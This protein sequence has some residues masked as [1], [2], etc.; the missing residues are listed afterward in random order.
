[1]TQ[2]SPHYEHFQMSDT[3][4]MEIIKRPSTALIADFLKRHKVAFRTKIITYPFIK[5]SPDIL[6]CPTQALITD[7]LKCP[8]IAL[9]IHHFCFLKD[10]KTRIITTILKSPTK[11]LTT[12]ILY[13]HAE[14]PRVELPFI[15]RPCGI[16][17]CQTAHTQI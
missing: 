12:N 16:L 11:Q 3:L 13:C 8:K 17:A 14:L 4:T 7:F 1:M 5:T 15:L 9:V 10:P 2:D 6:E